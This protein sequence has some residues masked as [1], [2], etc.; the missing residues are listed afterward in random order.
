MVIGD[1]LTMPRVRVGTHWGT[2]V[3]SFGCLA[4]VLPGMQMSAVGLA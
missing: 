4:L 1:W 3:V 2:L